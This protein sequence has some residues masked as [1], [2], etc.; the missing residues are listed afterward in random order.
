MAAPAGYILV[1]EDDPSVRLMITRRLESAGYTVR[2]FGS[3]YEGLAAALHDPPRILLLDMNLPDAS[4]LNIC[5]TVKQQ[6]NAKAPIIIVTSARGQ[7]ADVSAAR[8]AG[9]DDYLIKPV[10]PG[11]LLSHIQ[12]FDHRPLLTN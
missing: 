11:E 10:A 5:R 8:E 9:A 3:G 4:G 1:I 7:P 6:M 2:S 12:R